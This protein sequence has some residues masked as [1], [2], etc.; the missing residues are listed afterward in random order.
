[1]KKYSYGVCEW[2]VKA[3]GE[4]FVRMAKRSGLDCIQLGVGTEIFEGRGLADPAL[5]EEYRRSAEENGIEIISISPQFVDEYSFTMPGSCEEEQLVDALIEKTIEQCSTFGC[6]H[7][8]LPVLGRNDI[9][10]GPAFH[11]AVSCIQKYSQKAAEKGIE[12]DIEMN[13]SIRQVHDLLDAVD[14][15]MVK[16]FFDSQNLYAKDGTAMAPYFTTLYNEGLIGGIHFKDGKG[17]MLSGSLLGEGTSGFYKTA[18]AV[19]ESG[20]E[21]PLLIESVYSKPSV[22]GLGTEEELL[23]RDADTLHRI[24][25]SDGRSAGSITEFIERED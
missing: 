16:V 11:R 17:T 22:A 6:T 4:S 8:L 15:P 25:D 10:C 12:T 20:Y 3:R 5:V 21:G 1:M 18:K 13:Q 7:F 2:S 9:T 14:R 23:K 24:F 19:L